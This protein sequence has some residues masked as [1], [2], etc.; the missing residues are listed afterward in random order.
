LSGKI[1]PVCDG[2]T[3]VRY[4]DALDTSNPELCPACFGSGRAGNPA[5]RAVMWL[6]MGL[7][8]SVGLGC[9]LLV[10]ILEGGLK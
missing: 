1:C 4:E 6:A 10:F 5:R 7:G 8:T 2:R 3:V 9:T